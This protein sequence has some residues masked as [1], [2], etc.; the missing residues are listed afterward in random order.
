VLEAGPYE[1]VACELAGTPFGS[2][3]YVEE[4]ESTNA[5]A[6]MLLDEQRFGGHT[7]VAEYQRSGAGRKGRVWLAP[8]GTGLLFTT[9]LPRS[10]G[11][12]RLW[13]VPYW[14]ALAVRAALL[15]FGI[16]TTLQWPND[17]LC[18][19]RK[20]AGV[21]CQSSVS[22]SLARVACGVGI[23]VRRPGADPG[24]EPPPAYCDDVAPVDRAALLHTTLTQ[25][26]RR[27][28]MLD[29]PARVRVE[30]DEAAELPGRRYCIA[31]DAELE[32][33]EA[34]AQ[35]IDESGLRVRRPNG[36]EEIVSLAD[37][38]VVR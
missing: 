25:Y 18:G 37:A 35:G 3:A 29:D 28:F 34:V 13:I 24:I 2:I 20:I 15:D 19:E 14:V 33:F 17:L 12:E 4:T 10:I 1:T 16:A 7:I 27:L 21:L 31:R 23:N 38:R 30:W 11:S 9:I 5:D 36:A 26:A 8:A 22:G 6:A 32:T